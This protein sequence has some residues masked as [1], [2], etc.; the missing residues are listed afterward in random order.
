ME[1]K[2][3]NTNFTYK[4]GIYITSPEINEN[5]KNELP[6]ILT[7]YKEKKYLTQDNFKFPKKN[8]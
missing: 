5:T 2:N 6:Q 8:I 3:T 1:L 4:N 7:E